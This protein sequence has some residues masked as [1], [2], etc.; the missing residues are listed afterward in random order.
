MNRTAEQTQAYVMK[1]GKDV[2]AVMLS[3]NGDSPIFTCN[4]TT[5]DEKIR[6]LED[7]GKFIT[8]P[9]GTIT[10]VKDEPVQ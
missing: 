7:Y 9:N 4:K 1:E 2:V 3:L 6:L 10:V 5:W 8:P